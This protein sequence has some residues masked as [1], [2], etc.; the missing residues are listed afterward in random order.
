M[1]SVWYLITRYSD[2]IKI[3][4]TT[5]VTCTFAYTGKEFN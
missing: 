5:K 1:D 3:E 2:Y 4:K